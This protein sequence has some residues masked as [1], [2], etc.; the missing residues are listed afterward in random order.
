MRRPPNLC[1]FKIVGKRGDGGVLCLGC[2]TRDFWVPE[3]ATWVQ[4]SQFPF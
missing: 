1:I 3:Q 4:I 2:E